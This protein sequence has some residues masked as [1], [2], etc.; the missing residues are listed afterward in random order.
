MCSVFYNI[1]NLNLIFFYPELA[2]AKEYVSKTKAKLLPTLKPAPK[3]K[4]VTEKLK[5][6]VDTISVIDLD[7]E[8]EQED[9]NE[10]VATIDNVSITEPEPEVEP[11]TSVEAEAVIESESAVESEAV[12]ELEPV[13]E[14]K[15]VTEPEPVA[16][17]QTVTEHEH[18]PVVESVSGPEI[19]TE[20]CSLS[21]SGLI[22]DR[23]D[24]EMELNTTIEL[25]SD[26]ET[27]ETDANSITEEL[28]ITANHSESTSEMKNAT[29][30]STENHTISPVS[31]PVLPDKPVSESITLEDAESPAENLVD[32]EHDNSSPVNN[33]ISNEMSDN[34]PIILSDIV[35]EVRVNTVVSKKKLKYFNFF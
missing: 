1:F 25:N 8:V 17:L 33:L 22:A 11:N 27:G 32:S 35:I 20:Q 16:K 28:T 14:P 15:S 18:E 34:I 13:I 19:N 21:K 9:L 26:L 6:V 31:S 3:A 23:E 29:P 24:T 2:T 5:P 7:A 4:P 12:V 10:S 30:T